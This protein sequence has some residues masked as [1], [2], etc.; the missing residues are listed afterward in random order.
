MPLDANHIQGNRELMKLN[1]IAFMCS[2]K[3]PECVYDA[4]DHWMKS[5]IPSKDCVMCGNHSQIEQHVFQLLLSK[6]VP[7]IL[8]MAQAMPST[9]P[10]AQAQAIKQGRLLVITH[11]DSSVHWPTQQSAYDRNKLMIKLANQIVVGCCD[12]GGNLDKQL[13]GVANLCILTDG[14][15]ED[16]MKA[17]QAYA[18]ECTHSTI[19]QHKENSSSLPNSNELRLWD[20]RFNTPQGWLFANFQLDSDGQLCLYITQNYM[21]TD[22]QYA[23]NRIVIA[24]HL[25][26][27]F[28]TVL[29]DIILMLSQKDLKG[30]RNTTVNTPHGKVYFGLALNQSKPVLRITQ[31]CFSWSGQL[32]LQR[33]HV[34]ISCLPQFHHTI[35]EAAAL[36]AAEG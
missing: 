33:I 11:C 22:D 32:T 7:T 17:P 10:S 24:I 12:V 8:V 25:A 21:Q 35:H 31:D 3:A 2:R 20:R 9:F 19:Q 15:I 1:K 30:M 5:I 13:E 34:D 36:C 14:N 23:R 28:Y 4:I 26:A 18:F 29:S 27:T 16:M 6:H